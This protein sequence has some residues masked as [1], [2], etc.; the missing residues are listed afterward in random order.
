MSNYVRNMLIR[1]SA[2][3]EDAWFTVTVRTVAANE[4]FAVYPMKT[5]TGYLLID[6]GDGSYRQQATAS[7]THAYAV[8]G[9]YTISMRA[10]PGFS[11][12]YFYTGIANVKKIVSSNF[13]WSAL[14]VNAISLQQ[15]FQHAENL[16]GDVL[17]LPVNCSSL[18]WAFYNNKKITLNLDTCI[19]PYPLLTNIASAFAY[20][21]GVTGDAAAFVSRCAPGVVYTSAFAGTSCTNIP[22]AR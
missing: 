12:V 15:L 2:G 21:P 6:W 19:G 3:A 11:R 14:T 7:V 16:V 17:S 10:A 5:G 13:N 4:S 18:Q 1:R 22:A 9:D 8:P 20:S